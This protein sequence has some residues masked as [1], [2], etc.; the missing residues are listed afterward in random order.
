MWKMIN[1]VVINDFVNVI[2]VIGV[3]FIMVIYFCDVY[4]FS[5]VI[6]VF[7][8]NFGYDIY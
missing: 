5:F 2:L 4:D 3:F 8:I 1:N 7:L 6:G